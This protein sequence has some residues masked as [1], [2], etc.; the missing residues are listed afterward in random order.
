MAPKFK[1]GATAMVHSIGYF[2]PA[3]IM[4]AWWY[5]ES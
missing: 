4:I 3:G 2:V 5:G 1:V